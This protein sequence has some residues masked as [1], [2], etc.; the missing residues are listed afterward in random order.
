MKRT[1]TF[2]FSTFVA[3]SLYAQG[4]IEAQLKT[5]ATKALARCADQKLTIEPAPG[6]SPAGFVGY[7]F[8]QTSSDPSCGRKARLLYSPSTQQVL[9]GNVIPIPADS[10]PIEARVTAKATELLQRPMTATLQ[11]GF[12]LPDGLK[13]I[14]IGRNTEYGPFAYHAFVDATE[15]FLI[16]ASRGNLKTDP[17]KTFTETVGLATA[18][19]RGN[20][21][22]KIKIIELSDFQCPT[23]GRAHSMIEPIIVKNLSKIDYYRV[24]L[25]L[26]EH[27]EW[28]VPATMGARAIM[29]VAPKKYWDYVNYVFGNQEAIGKMGSFDQTLRNWVEDNDIS[30]QAIEKI[31]SSPT[32]RA[33]LMDHTSRLF[34]LGI[35]STPTYVINGQVMG[36]GPEGKFTIDAIKKAIASAK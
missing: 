3:V 2:L 36:Y 12:P 8:T 9:V 21:K 32:E 16:V 24:D 4:P 34:D 15:R 5:Y 31:Y 7:V 17:G 23:C 25:P 26:F 14:N 29:R 1:T 33:A 18:A 19:R 10:R 20:P 13:P 22:A 28:S 6:P 30:W 35:S 27:H 11:R